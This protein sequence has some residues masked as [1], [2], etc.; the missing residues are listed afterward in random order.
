MAALWMG[1][2]LEPHNYC[3][4]K[5]VSHTDKSIVWGNE[6]SLTVFKVYF[7]DYV[8]TVVQIFPPLP[9]STL[10]PCSLKQSPSQFMS[11][12]C[13]FKYFGF[14]ISYAILNS[15]LSIL[16]LPFMLL[17]PCMISLFSHFP[18]PADNPPNDLHIYD[19]VLLWLNAQGFF[20]VVG[21]DSIVDSCKFGAF[22]MF[23]VLFFIF[24]FNK[25]L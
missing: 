11:M 22:L 12:G 13:T 8:I 4:V 3:H 25:S 2:S 5:F 17:N 16:F 20:V 18:V 7:I 14:S 10:Y 6:V 24:F 1:G 15:L 23:M 9:P 21:F 19:C